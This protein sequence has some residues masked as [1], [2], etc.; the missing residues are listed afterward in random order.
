ML[1]NE[2]KEVLESKLEQIET[3]RLALIKELEN[4]YNIFQ[5]KVMK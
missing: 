5:E 4:N 1:L 2:S 3:N